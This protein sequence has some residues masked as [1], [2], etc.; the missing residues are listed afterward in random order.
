MVLFDFHR[1]NNKNEKNMKLHSNKKMQPLDELIVCYRGE[2]GDKIILCYS[3][4]GEIYRIYSSVVL[5]ANKKHIK[6]KQILQ[7]RI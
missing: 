1:K 4:G 7:K 2:A 3:R 5:R 6:R